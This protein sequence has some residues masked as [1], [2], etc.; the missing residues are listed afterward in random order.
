MLGAAVFLCRL[1]DRPEVEEARRDL[2]AVA[3]VGICCVGKAWFYF[4][5]AVSQTHP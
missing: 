1:H 2:L 3:A 4:V 5:I